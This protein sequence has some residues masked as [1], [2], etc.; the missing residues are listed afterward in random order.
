[1]IPKEVVDVSINIGL[2]K[3]L[4]KRTLLIIRLLLTC[5]N[6]TQVY[7]IFLQHKITHWSTKDQIARSYS[8]FQR[9]TL[10]LL[11]PPQ[12]PIIHPF[13]QKVH[14]HKNGN[15]IFFQISKQSSFSQ[16]LGAIWFFASLISFHMWNWLKQSHNIWNT[17]E[18][19][20]ICWYSL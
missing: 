12:K 14:R 16:D 15:I 13:D 6:C 8:Y 4:E 17:S 1:M 3:F 5:Q 2:L 9:E 11:M 7:H 18:M 10:L 20:T 19:L